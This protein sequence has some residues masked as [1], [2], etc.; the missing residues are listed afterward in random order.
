MIVVIRR[1]DSNGSSHKD[2]RDVESRLLCSQAQ[3]PAQWS[4]GIPGAVANRNRPDVPYHQE[5]WLS[6]N[7]ALMG[8]SVILWGFERFHRR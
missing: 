5:R 7:T 2:I 8:R 1:A 4:G 6:R 3:R